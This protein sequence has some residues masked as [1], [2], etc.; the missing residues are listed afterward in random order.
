[1]FEASPEH[2]GIEDDREKVNTLDFFKVKQNGYG[3]PKNL[4]IFPLTIRKCPN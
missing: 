3:L 1:M 2:L 4:P